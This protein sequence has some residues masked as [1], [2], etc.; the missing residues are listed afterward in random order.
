MGK[1]ELGGEG[2]RL[3]ETAEFHIEYY[4]R[5]LTRSSAAND[6]KPVT[7][8]SDSSDETRQTYITPHSL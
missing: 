3:N 6:K 1:F 8:S 7:S 4:R 2:N 5:R